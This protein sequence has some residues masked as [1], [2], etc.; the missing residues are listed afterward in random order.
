MA[1]TVSEPPTEELELPADER[2]RGA[3]GLEFLALVEAVRRH[4][5]VA[6]H[7]SEP[8]RP[9]DHALYRVVDELDR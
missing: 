7:P 5:A 9:A 6:D 2:P 8:K 4:R 3:V 1:A